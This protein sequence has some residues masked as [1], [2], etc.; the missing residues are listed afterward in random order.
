MLKN[1]YPEEEYFMIKSEDF[2]SQIKEI[3]NVD[4]S[5]KIIMI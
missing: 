1:K 4:L 2:D 3:L 5:T